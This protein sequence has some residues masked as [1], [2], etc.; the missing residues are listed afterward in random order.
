MTANRFA[1]GRFRHTGDRR[2]WGLLRENLKGVYLRSLRENEPQYLLAGL[3]LWKTIAYNCQ[4]ENY[5]DL[6]IVC[7]VL[8][9]SRDRIRNW[10]EQFRG[11]DVIEVQV[12][13]EHGVIVYFNLAKIQ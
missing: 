9:L 1:D 4:S 5:Q 7:E 6:D 2:N 10:L 12:R 3:H 13:T 8:A 11:G